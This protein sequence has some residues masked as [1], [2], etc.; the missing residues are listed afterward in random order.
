MSAWFECKV[1]YTKIDETTGKEKK[2]TE[3]YLIDAVS[4]TDA[5]SRIYKE[6][7]TYVSGEFSI[8]NIKV[9]KFAELLPNESGDRWFRV[10]LVYV[11]IDEEAGKERKIN[12]YLLVQ[13]NDIKEAYDEVARYMQNS[14]SDYTIP[15][16]S[17]SP[18][19][20]IFPF[21]SEEEK[22]PAN[23]KPLAEVEG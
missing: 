6:M 12:S 15:S 2:V 7:E 13:A 10:K 17:E 11:S 5:E 21:Y 23:L 14:V 16:I 20:D 4:F 22:I 8:S 9:V 1:K 3:P 19:M 18:I